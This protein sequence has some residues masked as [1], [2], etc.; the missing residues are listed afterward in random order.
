MLNRKS[1]EFIHEAL[2]SI[3]D[4]GTRE[5]TIKAIEPDIF[6]EDLIAWL[7]HKLPRKYA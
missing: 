5:E 2:A 7:V 3:A 4:P 1:N 6:T